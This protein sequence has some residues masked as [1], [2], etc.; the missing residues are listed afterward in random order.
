[1][2]RVP[3]LR[4]A[5]GLAGTSKAFREARTFDF[6]VSRVLPVHDEFIRTGVGPSESHTSGTETVNKRTKIAKKTS[7]LASVGWPPRPSNSSAR[8]PITPGQNRATSRCELG[9]ASSPTGRGRGS[10]RRSYK[11]RTVDGHRR[12]L[13][14]SVHLSKGSKERTNSRESSSAAGRQPT[15]RRNNR[16]DCST[17]PVAKTA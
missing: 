3:E 4:E 13:Q 10:R 1:M 6:G 17:V 11:L 14:V 8:R 12:R 16:F 5:N 7:V 15:V 9:C 2:H